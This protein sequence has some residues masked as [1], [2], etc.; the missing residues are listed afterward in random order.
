MTCHS[1]RDSSAERTFGWRASPL[2][3]HGDGAVLVVIFLWCSERELVCRK[4]H[5]IARFKYELQMCKI[6]F[7]SAWKV[8]LEVK[9]DYVSNPKRRRDSARCCSSHYDWHH[10][11]LTQRRLGFQV[12]YSH[13]G[14][15][16]W[17]KIT[18]ILV[19]IFLY[20]I[21]Y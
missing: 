16:Y 18:V 6:N 20:K 14:W 2:F 19:S 21:F 5:H 7:A 8:S 15:L 11:A 4:L 13:V 1:T 3:C 10:L 17:I 12:S 9:T